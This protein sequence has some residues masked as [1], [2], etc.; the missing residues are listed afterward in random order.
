MAASWKWD[1]GMLTVPSYN[2]VSATISQNMSGY[3]TDSFLV[4]L[5][6]ALHLCGIFYAVGSIIAS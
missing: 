3:I 1:K 2:N 5:C 6:T 4:C